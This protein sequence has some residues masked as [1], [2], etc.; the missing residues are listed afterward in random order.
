MDNLQNYAFLW[1]YTLY[2]NYKLH[3]DSLSW[4]GRLCTYSYRLLVHTLNLGWKIKVE[5]ENEA[6]YFYGFHYFML[7]RTNW[8][9]WDHK[10]DSIQEIF[11]GFHSRSSL[12]RFLFHLISFHNIQTSVFKFLKRLV[13]TSF[14]EG[15]I[16]PWA[17]LQ[18]KFTF[19]SNK[20][21]MVSGCLQFNLH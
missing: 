18:S 19:L 5:V 7:H 8:R 17:L 21:W 20:N 10:G 9:E 16:F 1:L 11:S 12:C 6:I 15:L 4:I 14:E 3:L 13:F 2:P